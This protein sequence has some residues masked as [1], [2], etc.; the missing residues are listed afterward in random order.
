MAESTLGTST[1]RPGTVQRPESH[2]GDALRAH[3]Y[4]WLGEALR[5]P[6]GQATLQRVQTQFRVDG[7]D[8]TEGSQNPSAL[9][10]ALEQL[11]REARRAD[12]NDLDD[13]YHALFI[14]LGRGELMPYGSWYLTGY[15]MGR[16]L[17]QLRSSLQALGLERQPHVCEPEDHAG[18]LCETMAL[19]ADPVDGVP[20][21]V[22]RE[23]YDSYLAP[24]LGSFFRDMQQ[25]PSARFYAAVGALGDAFG[26]VEQRYLDTFAAE[27]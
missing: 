2:I 15:L 4:A 1:E 3:L 27:S 16:P 8:G 9:R 12:L 19:L 22:Q 24:W 6:P 20:L 21:S 25:A 23:F 17:A 14:G 10:R 5:A 13:E 11:Q 26:E 7:D 18:A